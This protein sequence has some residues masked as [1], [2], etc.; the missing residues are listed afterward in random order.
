MCLY[1]DQ[2]SG[3][4]LQDHWSSG[5]EIIISSQLKEC[6]LF[7]TIQRL[8]SVTGFFKHG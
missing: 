5:I 8:S 2:I 3:E 6:S 7:A 4:R 1:E